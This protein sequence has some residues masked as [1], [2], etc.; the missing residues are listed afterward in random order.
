MKGGTGEWGLGELLFPSPF[1]RVSVSPFHSLA[2]YRKQKISAPCDGGHD[3]YA[4]AVLERGLFL[5]YEADVFIVHVYVDETADPSTLG[6][7]FLH[8]RIVL[9]QGVDKIRDVLRRALHF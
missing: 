2:S 6:E 4:V 9:L 7:P 3:G 1:L 8:T 5:V